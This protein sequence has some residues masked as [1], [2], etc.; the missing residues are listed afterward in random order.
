MRAVRVLSHA[1]PALASALL[2]LLQPCRAQESA[3]PNKPI[4]IVVPFA[5]G[6]S[7]DLVGRTLADK[8]GPALGQQVVIINRPGASGTI[9]TQTVAAALPDGYTLGL[10]SVSALVL[11][12]AIVKPRPYEALADFTP[13]V[14]VAKVPEATMASA[15]SGITSFAQLISVA[16]ANPG[17]L[18]YASTGVG[19]LAHLAAAMLS[20]ETGIDMVHVPYNGGAPSL[21]DLLAGRVQITVNDLPTYLP[22]VMS[23]ALNALAINGPQRSALLPDVPTTAELGYPTLISENWFGLVAPA[24]TPPGIIAK[25]NRAVVEAMA[26]AGVK[27]A[28]GRSGVVTAGDTPEEFR[29]FVTAEETRWNAIIKTVFA[30]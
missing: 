18:S 24:H 25:L 23:G 12:P 2:C 5:P 30:Q 19:S 1:V 21:S 28:L 13:I 10:P 8:L 17:K 16:K 15:K 6:G 9:G 20:H 29:A 7:N 14:L 27:T 4:Q 3:Y 26:D 11:G 22:H